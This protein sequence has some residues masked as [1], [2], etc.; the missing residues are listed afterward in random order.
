MNVGNRQFATLSA[1]LSAVSWSLGPLWQSASALS[2]FLTLRSFI[3]THQRERYFC[4]GRFRI[5][6]VPLLGVQVVAFECRGG[7]HCCVVLRTSVRFVALTVSECGL[8]C[9]WQGYGC[10]R[11]G[12][13]EI[14]WFFLTFA[15]FQGLR[16]LGGRS[17][18]CGSRSLARFCCHRQISTAAFGS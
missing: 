6:W 18:L 3:Q 7:G 2:F 12:E 8:A 15:P 11:N 10:L 5:C 14:E 4:P 16:F 17:S 9:N 1:Y 13:E